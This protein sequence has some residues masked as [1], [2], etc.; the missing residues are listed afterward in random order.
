MFGEYSIRY[1]LVRNFYISLD[2]LR[3]GKRFY[4]IKKSVDKQLIPKGYKRY[5]ITTKTLDLYFLEKTR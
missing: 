2:D 1:Y 5:P 4:L 3:L